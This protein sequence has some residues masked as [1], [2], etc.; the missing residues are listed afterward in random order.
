MLNDTYRHKDIMNVYPDLSGRSLVS[1]SEKGILNLP[2]ERDAVGRG[3]VRRYTFDEVIQAGV[4]R[5]LM[6]HGL[7]FRVI[8]NYFHQ[9]WR[10]L[11]EQ[12]NYNC[13]FILQ[14][15]T[16]RV[17]GRT[18]PAKEV[19]GKIEPPEYIPVDQ[20]YTGYDARG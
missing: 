13:V 10:D 4:I 3:S 1:W 17:D 15:R 2:P 6:G 5:E 9:A 18:E 12:L 14:R 7:T 11:I 8:K 19:N 16:I 20:L